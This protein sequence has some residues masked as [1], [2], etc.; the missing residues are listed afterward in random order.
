[1]AAAVMSTTEATGAASY[2]GGGMVRPRVAYRPEASQAGFY[3]SGTGFAG[4]TSG[5]AE[6]SALATT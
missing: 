5:A 2:V 1:M 3:L 4:T 6:I